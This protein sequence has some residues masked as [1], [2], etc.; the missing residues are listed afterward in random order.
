MHQLV[1][2]PARRRE[3]QQPFGVDVEAADRL[4]LALLQARQAAEHRRAVLR[5]VVGDDL[6]GRLVVRDD[7][8]R[9]RHDAQAHRLAVDLDPIAERDP[10]A[11]VRRLAIDGDPAFLDRLFHV[12]ARSDSGLRQDFVQLGRVRLRGQDSLARFLALG[13]LG[14]FVVEIAGEHLGEDF[15]GLDRDRRLQMARQRSF[16]I[17]RQ[18]HRAREAS[19]V[20][21]VVAFAVLPALAAMPIAP[22]ATPAAFAD[23]PKAG[24]ALTRARLACARDVSGVVG[25]RS[26]RNGTIAIRAG[27][28]WCRGDRSA[29]R[30]GRTC[31]DRARRFRRPHRFHRAHRARRSTRLL[32]RRTGDFAGGGL[33]TAPRGRRRTV[34]G[35]RAATSAGAENPAAARDLRERS[36]V[37]FQGICGSRR[38]FEGRLAHGIGHELDEGKRRLRFT[39]G[40]AAGRRHRLAVGAFERRQLLERG[41]GRDRRGTGASSRTAPAG[42]APRDSRSPRSSRDPRAA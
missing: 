4:P 20:A 12:A 16:E 18:R 3:E 41:Q 6:A 40:R 39:I 42:L 26:R 15:R 14:D 28:G 13:L 36:C 37:W 21:A 23:R 27:S 33:A 7:P 1:G 34:L 19:L 11:G 24:P 9:R 8:R 29:S 25:A 38:A 10:L 31:I 32:R 2:E 30:F 5:V 35:R 22:I 17:R